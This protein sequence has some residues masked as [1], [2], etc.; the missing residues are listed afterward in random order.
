MAETT[1]AIEEAREGRGQLLVVQAAAGLGKTSLLAAARHT[2]RETGMRVLG[3]RG[4]ELE[5]SFPF[6]VVRQLF[7][8]ALYAASDELRARWLAGAAELAKP[9]FDTSAAHQAL[10]ADDATYARLHGLYWLCCNMAHEQPLLICVDDAHWSDD[11]SVKFL[12]FI[13]R[14]LE[15]VAMLVLVG[16]RPDD[17]ALS[18]QLPTLV[19]D[20]GARRLDL[21]PLSDRAVREW[22]RSALGAEAAEEFCRACHGATSGNPLLMRELIREVSSERVAPTAEHA[23]R[24]EALGSHGVSAVVLLRLARLPTGARELARAVAVLGDT[25]NLSLAGALAGLADGA[26]SSAAEALLRAE[27]LVGDD[28][29]SFV[30]PIV[31][32]AI[33]ENIS[34]VDRPDHHARAARLLAQRR[35]SP[36]AIAAQLLETT[37]AAEEWVVDALREAAVL[38]LGLG[39]SKVAVTYLTRALAEPPPEA[40][41]AAALAELGRAEARTG[42]PGAVEHLEQAIAL[43]PDPREAAAAAL[44]L[45]GLLKFAGD[46]VRAVDVLERAQAR[47]RD[48]APDLSDRLEVEL[49]GCAYISVSARRMLADKVAKLEDCG[50]APQTFLERFKLA[51]MC[52]DA[53]AEGKHRDHVTDLATRALAG[54]D[55]PTDPVSGGHAFVSAAIGLMFSERYEDAERLYSGMLQDART[56]GSGVSFATAASLRSLVNYRRGRLADG[57]ADARAALNLAG[58]V[59]G[60]QGFLSAA[61]G[62]LIYSSLDRGTVDDALVSRADAFLVEQATDNLPY[63]HAIH[64]RASLHVWAGELQRGLDGFLAS[65]RRELEWGAPNPAITPWRSSAA[66]VLAQLG[67]GEEARRLA[68]EEVALARAF[69]APRCLGVALR[70]AGLVHEGSVRVQLLREAVDVLESSYGVLELARSLIDLGAAIRLAGAATDARTLLARGQELAMSCGASALVERARQELR[71][72]GARPRRAA[73]SGIDSLTPSERRVAQLASEGM[74]NREIAQSLFV[75]EK[76]VETH[77]GN[78]YAKLKIRSRTEL[79]GAFAKPVAA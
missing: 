77:L 38:A 74:G 5:S 2:A 44:E 13:G 62:T 27:I 54:G 78:A 26:A 65:G 45:A 20:P 70:A 47:L 28:G 66:L 51:G 7:E 9:M 50:G 67:D 34:A 42:A 37:P 69:G 49:I 8:S 57:E 16:T 18:P 23:A 79:P 19:A 17:E 73:V 24:V 46:S 12:S 14:R 31:R 72:A 22:V 1:A 15:D 4:S 29:L 41:R 11:P 75:T 60:S 40:R 48:D 30:H 21:A 35:C 52:F 56:R 36:Q 6:G 63:S 33:Y 39:D 59:H 71:A 64:S 76:T 10:D 25:A 58:E 32:A 53:F 68:S 43:A 3:A 55:L 61:L